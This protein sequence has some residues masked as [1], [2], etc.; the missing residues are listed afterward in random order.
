MPPFILHPDLQSPLPAD[1][2]S[3]VYAGHYEVKAFK[4]S[5]FADIPDNLWA[6]AS[7]LVCYHEVTVNT[8]LLNRMPNCRV[9]VRAGVG[10]DNIDLKA[11]GERGIAVCNTP[12]YGTTDVADHAIA[13]TMALLRGITAYNQ[14]ILMDP[15]SGWRFEGAPH[16]RRL[17]TQVFGV[18]GLGRIGT[19]TALRARAL[20][21][22]VVF[23][24]PYRTT[25]TELSLGIERVGSLAA[26]L[27]MS[28]V[29]SLHTPLSAETKHMMNAET[30]R[31]MK[32][33]A[34]LINT[35]RGGCVDLE[36]LADALL[37]RRVAAAGLDV[38]E[39]EP[40]SEASALMTAW[41]APDS[42]IRDRLIV[43]PHAAFYS[44]SSL[45]DL[46]SKSA[47]TALKFLLTG[48]SR[49]CANRDFLDPAK[50]EA[51]AAA[52]RP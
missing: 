19:A 8:Q 36:A 34:V 15:R 38:L 37:S 25:G 16:V 13:L 31:Q 21:M 2:E 20:G 40:P 50:A 18:V 14:A 10:F 32:P 46:R 24:D 49:D 44:P 12:D 30:L 7:G 28:D 1:I 39:A 22:R 41:R 4:P 33:G 51:R 45:I 5:D 42:P 52:G 3:K 23:F 26:L 6:G 9:V 11:A 29:V 47:T 17:S 27:E 48:D 35:G 43:T